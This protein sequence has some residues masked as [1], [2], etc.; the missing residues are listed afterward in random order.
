MGRSVDTIYHCVQEV[1]RLNSEIERDQQEP[2]KYPPLTSAFVEF[3]SPKAAYMACK[4][5]VWCAPLCLRPHYLE[6]SPVNVRWENLSLRWWNRYAWGF[7]VVVLVTALILAWS[8]P[9]AFTGLLSQIGSCGSTALTTL[10]WRTFSMAA[11]LHWRYITSSNPD[12][13]YHIASFDTTHH[14]KTSGSINRSGCR[15][16]STKVL[17]HVLV[18]TSF[19]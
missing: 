14:H 7:V 6:A 10:G 11:W 17:F 15:A 2:E 13:T 19:F 8:V 4:S 12:R 16:F 18:C 5:L 9:V 3:N 1:A